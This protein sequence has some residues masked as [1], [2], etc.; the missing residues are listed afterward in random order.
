MAVEINWNNMQESCIRKLDH[1]LKSNWNLLKTTRKK[2]VSR[3]NNWKWL[4]IAEKKMPLRIDKQLF[5]YWICM[6]NLVTQCVI[7][8]FKRKTIKFKIIF[9]FFKSEKKENFLFASSKCSTQ[10]R[11]IKLKTYHVSFYHD[12]TLLPCA[13]QHDV[14]AWNFTHKSSTK[15]LRSIFIVISRLFTFFVWKM[16]IAD[17]VIILPKISF[18]RVEWKRKN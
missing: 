2:P 3:E 11:K 8:L 17:I 13:L 4:I 1:S 9:C 14:Y 18:Q 16:T 15:C 6:N 12:E 10:L 5:C 7:F